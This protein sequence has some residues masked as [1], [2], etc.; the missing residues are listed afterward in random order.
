MLMSRVTDTLLQ[1]WKKPDKHAGELNTVEPNHISETAL[2]NS[3]SPVVTIEEPELVPGQGCYY[4]DTPSISP[5]QI[6]TQLN[7]STDNNETDEDYYVNEGCV[8]V[9]NSAV[10]LS[11][12]LLS[13]SP[14]VVVVSPQNTSRSPTPEQSHFGDDD[15]A[16]VDPKILVVEAVMTGHG[17]VHSRSASNLKGHTQPNTDN[18]LQFDKNLLSHQG[19][20]PLSSSMGNIK[21]SAGNDYT[22]VNPEVE[23]ALGRNRTPVTTRLSSTYDDTEYGPIYENDLLAGSSYENNITK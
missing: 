7:R 22:Y 6:P 15:F 9:R 10:S 2:Q 3:P 17:I 18:M 1:K 23:W 19:S 20:L 11:P 8:I 13:T 16:F 14:T 4:K 21:Q 12:P 5:I